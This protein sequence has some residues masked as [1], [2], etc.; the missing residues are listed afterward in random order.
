MIRIENPYLFFKSSIVKKIVIQYLQPMK[1]CIAGMLS[2]LLVAIWLC[3]IRSKLRKNGDSYDTKRACSVICPHN[4][5][6][7]IE[8]ISIQ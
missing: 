8:Q 7:M 1:L 2:G 3:V 4:S 5:K 6:C